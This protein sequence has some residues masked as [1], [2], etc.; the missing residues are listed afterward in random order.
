MAT[1]DYYEILG[2][3]RSA[4][5]EEIKKAYH[6]LAVQYHPDKNPDDKAAEERFKDVSEAY[7]VL[8]DAQKRAQYDR[9]GHEGVQGGYAGAQNV[10]PLEIF[11]DFMSGRGF[12]GIE[13]IFDAF[14]G[15]SFQSRRGATRERRGEDLQIN[16]KLTLEEIA[17]GVEKKLRLARLAT[18]SACRGSGAGP[19][20]RRTRC[21]QCD[22]TGE[23]RV[24]QRSL[25]GQVV[26]SVAC[27]RCS[28]QGT[29]IEDP[30][31]KC[32]GEGRQQVQEEILIKVPAGVTEGQRLVKRGGGN[33]GRR[34]G[35]P[36]DLIVRI[37][38]E[39]HEYFERRGNDLLLRMPVSLAQA[40][41]GAK[42]QVPSLEGSVEL[43]LPAGIQSGK[44]LRVRDH[45]LGTGRDRGDLY[46]EVRIW[47]PQKLSA[48]E[49]QLLQ[50]LGDLPGQQPPKPGRGFSE[51]VRDAFGS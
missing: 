49:K 11:R 9:F 42:I 6:R 32:H 35:S 36:G 31:P 50:E 5:A 14:M 38:E 37:L 22:G 10:D 21:T 1:K 20:G 44:L 46:V 28:G 47:T 51:K 16:L 39:P 24:V 43:K 17:R 33:V 18:C 15:G 27:T 2:I 12:G 8:S 30:C 29:I 7:Q 34:E 4:S 19:S 23:I 25:W 45:G 3:D 13:D 48:K 41:L 26:Q 40:A